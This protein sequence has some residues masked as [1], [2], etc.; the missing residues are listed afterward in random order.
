LLV[1]QAALGAPTG[2]S[3]AEPFFAAAKRSLLVLPASLLTLRVA[4]WPA[5]AASLEAAL[6]AGATGF[7]LLEDGAG[8][9]PLYETA[10]ALRS[11]L[12]GRALLLVADR[13]DVAAAADADGVLL[14]PAALPTTVARRALPDS[15]LVL[16]SLTDLGAVDAAAKDGAD[17]LLLDTASPVEPR[18]LA[19]AAARVTVPLLVPLGSLPA[20]QL[21][22]AGASG[23]VT[24]LGAGG[25]IAGSELAAAM[26]A[27]AGLVGGATLVEEAPAQPS[28]PISGGATPSSVGTAGAALVA[29][30]RAL[31]GSILDFLASEVPDIPEAALL[32]E[33]RGALDDPFL[34][35]VAGEFNSGKSSVINALLGASVL[36]EGVLPTTNEISV[37]RASP[38][39]QTQAPGQGRFV[40]CADGHFDVF[41]A[42][43][44]LRRVS[45]VDTPGT[46]VILERQQRLTEEFIPRADLV[47]FVLSA[48]RPLTQSE[49]AF[50]TYIRQW[51]KRV[52]FA[53]NKVDTL[54]SP[55]EVDEVRAF[56]ASN[57]AQLLGTSGGTGEVF[58]VSARAALAAKLAISGQQQQPLPWGRPPPA[59]LSQP[60]WRGSGFDALEA[61]VSRFLGGEGDALHPG[62]ALRLKLLTPL[63]L[64]AALLDAAGRC[65]DAQAGV[66][67]A[68]LAGVAAVRRQLGAYQTD[69]A[70]DGAIQRARVRDAVRAASQR[71]E[72]FVDAQLRLQNTRLLASLWRSRQPRG[73]D[74]PGATPAAAREDDDDGDGM[75]EAYMAQV[76]A[77]SM[78]DLRGGV[79]EH[80][81]WLRRNAQRQVDHYRDVVRARGFGSQGDRRRGD[82]QQQPLP[83]GSAV[84]P[85]GGVSGGDAAMGPA[86]QASA[87][88][89]RFDQGAAALLLADE[90]RQAALSTAGSAGTALAVGTGLVAVLPTMGED[91]LSLA[92]G[93]V[94]A[95]VGLLNLPLR[96]AE[97]KA[98]VARAAESFGGELEAAMEAE[99][100]ASLAQVAADVAALVAP[101]EAAAQAEAAAVAAAQARAEVEDAKLRELQQRV[102]AL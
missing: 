55:A 67:A 74:A 81:Q 92:L 7:V 48:D 66:A 13:P 28:A 25:G 26:A 101:W 15:R 98:K 68:E 9:G 49:V 76:V 95:Y 57:A 63:S 6:Q 53:L 12:R 71:A 78:E 72:R 46:N 21:Q 10:C 54:A 45:I 60:G 31:L 34:L 61:F 17:G 18:A 35:V 19:A 70:K 43:P 24:Q 42:T 1:T 20:A 65:L 91:V 73:D 69:M 58:P 33:A 47:L 75:V 62:E 94:A 79:G 77:S 88:A 32:E 11:V 93:G 22:Q 37:L 36:R 29:H 80:S 64:A 96:R 30:E 38:A 84:T 52:V 14:S 40:A 51:E 85:V 39:G 97:V 41:L 2:K 4:D 86:G 56:V 8:A 82:A 99:L 16:R 59:L 5:A 90:I 50:L 87:V 100:Q 23:V 89:D 83:V 27:M 102:L 3:A 44:L